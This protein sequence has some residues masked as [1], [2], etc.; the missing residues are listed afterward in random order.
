MIEDSLAGV[1]AGLLA[2]MQVRYLPEYFQY[3]F[4]ADKRQLDEN[5]TKTLLCTF[6]V[7]TVASV[8]A[9]SMDKQR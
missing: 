9:D 7:C 4:P 8:M 5:K 3:V 2:G 1:E 6:N